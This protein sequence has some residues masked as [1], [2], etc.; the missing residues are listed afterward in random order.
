MLSSLQLA[1]AAKHRSCR[2]AMIFSAGSGTQACRYWPSTDR[3]ILRNRSPRQS[4]FAQVCFW[5]IAPQEPLPSEYKYARPLF[6]AATRSWRVISPPPAPPPPP[7]TPSDVADQQTEPA[8]FRV[9][10]WKSPE[11][12]LLQLVMT[13]RRPSR[14]SGWRV[15]GS[16]SRPASNRASSQPARRSPHRA[17]HF[18][19]TSVIVDRH[20]PRQDRIAVTPALRK[21]RLTNRRKPSMSKKN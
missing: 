2:L 5:T 6:R 20:D 15:S 12:L 21:R 14:R 18:L 13:R 3:R 9:K 16:L 10:K 8:R 17:G 4:V 1:L 7:P 19:Q 11:N